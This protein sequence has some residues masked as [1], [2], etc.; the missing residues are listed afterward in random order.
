MRGQLNGDRATQTMVD[1][2]T[3][4]IRAE[5]L[6]GVLEPGTRIH[7]VRT[8]ERLNMST[9]PVREALGSLVAEGLVVAV[10]QRGFRVAELD[11]QEL[12]DV[13]QMRLVLDP[14]AVRWAVPRLTEQDKAV[15]EERHA[16]LANAPLPTALPDADLD[17]HRRLHFAIYEHCGSEWLLRFLNTLWDRSQRYQL[18][19]AGEREHL[20][21]GQRTHSHALIVQACLAGEAEAAASLMASHLRGT[22]DRLGRFLPGAQVRSTPD[23]FRRPGA[24]SVP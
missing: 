11:P 24:D 20:R 16:V 17:A 12:F 19:S 9:V 4:T 1:R 13:Y 15:I 7:L 5:I 14:L 18:I 10:R 8:A 2:A 22:V 21:P 3:A 23:S 6:Q